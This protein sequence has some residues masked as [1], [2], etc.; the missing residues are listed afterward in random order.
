MMYVSKEVA[1]QITIASSDTILVISVLFQDP[2]FR[3][4]DDQACFL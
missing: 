1:I 3:G 2:F 4:G